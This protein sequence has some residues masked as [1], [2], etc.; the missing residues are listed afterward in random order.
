MVQCIVLFEVQ[1]L[2]LIFVQCN[3]FLHHDVTLYSDFVQF[4][5]QDL[6]QFFHLI[7]HLD[8]R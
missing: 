6:L 8:A 7:R 4:F 1:R 2:P 5:H 3:D